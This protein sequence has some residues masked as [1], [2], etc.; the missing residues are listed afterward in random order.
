MFS[1]LVLIHRPTERA[2]QKSR[3]TLVEDFAKLGDF[4]ADAFFFWQTCLRQML[5]IDEETLERVRPGLVRG[6]EI[7]H[8][9][10]AYQ[11]LLQV[12]CGLR[13]P[14]VGETEVYGQFKNAVALY[15]VKTPAVTPWDARLRRFFKAMFE[16]AKSVRQAHLKDLGSQSYGSV[17]RREMKAYK[18]IHILGAGQLVQEILPWIAKDGKEIHVYARDPQ[19]ARES[20]GEKD[21]AILHSLFDV[22]LLGA[23]DA[24]VIAAPISSEFIRGWMVDPSNLKF[25][26]DLRADSSSDRVLLDAKILDLAQVFNRISTNQTLLDERKTAALAAIENAVDERNQYVEYRP[27]G[28][29]DVCA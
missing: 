27:F 13:S 9:D 23:A 22:E 14:L 26:A 5:I 20:L 24:L 4:S 3:S 6:D 11:F 12:I 21:G 19:K 1:D 7:Y 15:S 25:I 29:E 16:D 18:K 17:L 2:G 28:W 8:G 10:M